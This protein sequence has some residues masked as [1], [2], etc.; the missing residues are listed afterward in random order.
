VR[1]FSVSTAIV[2]V[3]VGV[4]TRLA[5]SDP[6]W[7]DSALGVS[8]RRVGV[9]RMVVAWMYAQGAILPAVVGVGLRH[10]LNSALWLGVTLEGVAAIGGVL[11]AGVALRWR[12]LGGWVYGPAGIL[13]WGLAVGGSW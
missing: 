10:G 11:A 6:A 12:G 3:V 2:L 8:A 5:K 13:I 4:P 7:L 1:V 9:A